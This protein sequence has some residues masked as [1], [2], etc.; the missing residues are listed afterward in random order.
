MSRKIN[1]LKQ[2]KKKV[3]EFRLPKYSKA[4][5]A[6]VGDNSGI[7]DLISIEPGKETKENMILQKSE[8]VKKLAVEMSPN[9]QDKNNYKLPELPIGGSGIIPEDDFSKHNIK[10]ISIFQDDPKN[11]HFLKKKR[12]ISSERNDTSNSLDNKSQL[13]EGNEFFSYINA[14]LPII[15][16]LVKFKDNEYNLSI[17]NSILPIVETNFQS[18][19]ESIN[20]IERIKTFT[21]PNGS[22]YT[23]F[24]IL[25]T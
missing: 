9:D 20:Q 14:N 18:N 11:I 4:T 6:P 22:K 3:D 2:Q 8:V 21:Y 19:S 12:I 16:P 13:A 7:L 15:T 17:H 1:S 23:G 10:S 24:F 5:K 25:V